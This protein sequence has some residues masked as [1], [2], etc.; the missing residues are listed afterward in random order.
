MGANAQHRT[1]ADSSILSHV[2]NDVLA[3]GKTLRSESPLS[4]PSVPVPDTG[5]LGTG[6]DAASGG[7]G[8]SFVGIAALVALAF[9]AAPR[10]I[11]ALRTTRRLAAPQPF[12]SLLERP[13]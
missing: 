11:W 3:Y 12:L 8:L 6:G 9:L 10:M 2:T 13:G 7:L 1:Q 5:A 4:N